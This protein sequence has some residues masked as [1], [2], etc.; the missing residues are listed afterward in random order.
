MCVSWNWFCELDGMGQT[1]VSWNQLGR[2]GEGAT[3]SL[4]HDEVEWRNRLTLVVGRDLGGGYLHLAD[5]FLAGKIRQDI[6]V[7]A[8]GDRDFAL[9]LGTAAASCMI[10]W[11]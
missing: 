5:Q 8:I 11:S 10:D 9:H 2:R 7:A 4:L 1:C 3:P 6:R